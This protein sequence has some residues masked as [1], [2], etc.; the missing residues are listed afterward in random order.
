M[1]QLCVPLVQGAE[2]V[3]GTVV[4]TSTVVA[5]IYTGSM[6]I[7][8]WHNIKGSGQTAGFVLVS[9]FMG[10]ACSPIMMGWFH[11]L[12]DKFLCWS[13]LAFI[14]APTWVL[15]ESPLPIDHD[16]FDHRDPDEEVREG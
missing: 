4:V 9:L 15:I 3:A 6:S 1:L 14:L 12:V 2:L 13:I 10:M 5:L 7:L 11:E 16:S 8:H